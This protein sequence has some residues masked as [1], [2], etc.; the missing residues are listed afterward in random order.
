M[1]KRQRVSSHD[2]YQS[3]SLL[4]SYALEEDLF[5][6]DGHDVHRHR[7][8]RARLADDALGAVAR[9]P[10]E[11]TAL[12]P[13][14]HDARRDK[15]RCG[16]FAVEYELNAAVLFAEIIERAGHHGAP[17]IDDG[18]IIRDLVHLGVLV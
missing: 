11:H 13:H 3:M 17:P 4:R 1:K 18:D 16:C 8:E 6:R 9:Q 14:S 5:Q 2:L 12:P 7:V 10:R 15:Y